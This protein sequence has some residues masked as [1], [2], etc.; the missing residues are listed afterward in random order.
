MTFALRGLGWASSALQ[1]RQQCLTLRL[2]RECPKGE[3]LEVAVVVLHGHSQDG[4]GCVVLYPIDS[5]Q[6]DSY[7]WWLTECC[8]VHCR[9]SC[10][11]P[12]ARPILIIS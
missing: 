4:Y 8:F 10:S 5:R 11:V 1:V 2:R 9:R 6:A 3:R 12:W 7:A